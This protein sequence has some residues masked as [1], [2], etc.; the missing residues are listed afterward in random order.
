MDDVR[1]QLDRL[2]RDR[3][4]GCAALSRML[5]RNPAYIQQFIR[6]GTPRKLDEADRQM[7]ARYF[8]VEEVLLGGPV[9]RPVRQPG[10]NGG[11]AATVA[12]VPRLQIGASAGP[13]ALVEREAK[14][15]AIG[16]DHRWLRSLGANP[17]DV[18]I[19]QV[20]G[21][22]MAP[23]LADGDDIMVSKDDGVNRVRDG[24]YVLRVDDT[25]MV[26]RL[27]V[28]PA[29]GALNIRSDN[30]VYPDFEDCDPASVTVIGR[31]IWIGRRLV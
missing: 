30:P 21:D 31:V 1:E 9:G 17:G 3:G 5:G 27:S 10:H 6:R 20:R 12:M 14:Q 28:N 29:S 25:L 22:S 16:F 24:I 2:I 13:G 15:S 7:L 23:T 4:E 19:I 18:S 11:T 26:K 8:G